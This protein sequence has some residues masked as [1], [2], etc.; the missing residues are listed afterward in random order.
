MYPAVS[1]SK[2]WGVVGSVIDT[3][4]SIL[5]HLPEEAVHEIKLD[6]CVKIW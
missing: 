3:A 6:L 5:V 2:H 1:S 4:S